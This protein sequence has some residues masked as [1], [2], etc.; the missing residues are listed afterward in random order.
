M[1][2]ERFVGCCQASAIQTFEPT[3]AKGKG[4]S[5][6]LP[7]EKSSPKCGTQWKE[8][9]QV[10]SSSCLAGSPNW[11]ARPLLRQPSEERLRFLSSCF[12]LPEYQHIFQDIS[13]YQHIFRDISEYHHIFQD[14]SEY[15][16]IFQDI[17]G[18][19]TTFAFRVCHPLPAEVLAVCTVCHRAKTLQ[20]WGLK[21]LNFKVE[22]WESLN[23]CLKSCKAA[24]GR[25]AAEVRGQL[26]RGAV[27][28]LHLGSHRRGPGGQEQ[29]RARWEV[30]GVVKR[31]SSLFYV[32]F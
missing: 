16:H 11:I 2:F 4:K 6:L 5:A 32:F 28:Q 24:A 1:E 18:S 20:S 29:G 14:I 15:Q 13:E 30:L 8:I 10:K 7:P 12:C 31:F 9:V 3:K 27:Q 17:L 25:G 23:F 21:K 22:V 19:K 26:V